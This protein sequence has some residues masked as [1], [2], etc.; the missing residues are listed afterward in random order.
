LFFYSSNWG[1]LKK[2]YEPI[3]L[4]LDHFE[5]LH[6]TLMGHVA[7][8]LHSP[9]F[10]HDQVVDSI[11]FWPTLLK[12][13]VIHGV[14]MF[15]SVTTTKWSF[16]IA[17]GLFML[18]DSARFDRTTLYDFLQSEVET[19][20][21]TLTDQQKQQFQNA[22]DKACNHGVFRWINNFC[23][24]GNSDTGFAIP[25]GFEKAVAVKGASIAWLVDD[26]YPLIVPMDYHSFLIMKSLTKKALPIFK[27]LSGSQAQ[28]SQQNREG[29]QVVDLR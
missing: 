19:K 8:H 15:A 16:S 6:P 7:R 26:S 14:P 28:V 13:R 22:R 21:P 29:W 3:Q 20:V 27:I 12:Q 9:A 10:K 11:K 5:A 23:L 17:A 2:H 4:Y 1:L 24:F 18:L 25:G